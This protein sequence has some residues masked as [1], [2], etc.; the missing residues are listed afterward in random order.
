MRKSEALRILEAELGSTPQQA[1]AAYRRQAMKWH[2]DRNQSPGARAK[3]QEVASAHKI[4]VE[5]AENGQWLAP[6]PE[7]HAWPAT[8]APTAP[9]GVGKAAAAAPSI[10]VKEKSVQERG[11]LFFAS[12]LAMGEKM[13]REGA[14]AGSAGAAM[15]QGFDFFLHEGCF[16]PNDLPTLRGALLV[17]FWGGRRPGMLAA[18]ASAKKWCA[19]KGWATSAQ[20]ILDPCAAQ[21]AWSDGSFYIFD[22]AGEALPSKGASWADLAFYREWVA[23]MPELFADLPRSERALRTGLFFR[24]GAKRPLWMEQALMANGAIAGIFVPMG[25]P[26]KFNAKK[27]WLGMAIQARIPPSKLGSWLAEESS[28]GLAKRMAA[29]N[30]RVAADFA[31]CVE[32]ILAG[33]RQ[34]SLAGPW[35]SPKARLFAAGHRS[36]LRI[37]KDRGGP[38]A[39]T[40]FLGRKKGKAW[41]GRVAAV[42][43][44]LAKIEGR[45]SKGL[46]AAGPAA[47]LWIQGVPL[48]AACG[49][50]AVFEE[51]APLDFIQRALAL[52]RVGGASAL[53]ERDSNGLSG[54]DWFE[55]ALKE[56]SQ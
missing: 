17:V 20:I 29:M 33:R 31:P 18:L 1:K 56:R 23:A 40:R 28:E 11:V 26:R 52:E 36:W 9:S 49:L 51:G 24:G 34:W 16:G 44:S 45:L 37:E 53:R 19:G 25:T 41:E 42:W 5:L 6:E 8:Q 13:L 54:L 12:M 7:S 10:R 50:R 46:M 21:W 2:P 22:A 14:G 47:S 55:I 35:A 39:W 3:F 32:N 4:L 43:G 48:G 15:G 30:M 38:P 27:D